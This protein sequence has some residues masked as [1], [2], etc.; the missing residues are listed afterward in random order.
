MINGKK[1]SVFWWGLVILGLSVVGLFG[2]FW[3]VVVL[4][5]G[6]WTYMGGWRYY[7]PMIF[8]G[9]V[10]LLIGLYMMI[11]GVKKEKLME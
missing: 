9:V 2:L 7:V 1:T 4:G 6:S 3:Y 5:W 8:G 11:S 10:F